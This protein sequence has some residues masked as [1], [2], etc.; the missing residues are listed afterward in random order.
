MEHGNRVRTLVRFDSPRKA[1]IR[2]DAATGAGSSL[3][4]L[5]RIVAEMRHSGADFEDL[6][7]RYPAEW[8]VLSGDADGG[9]RIAAVALSASERRLHRES[10]QLFRVLAV[11][12]RALCEASQDLDT[13]VV[14]HGVGRTDLPTLRG[15]VRAAEYSVATGRGRLFVEPADAVEVE[16]IVVE[17]ADCRAERVRGLRLLG[18]DVR[19]EDLRTVG[20][21]SSPAPDREGSLFH[22]AVDPGRAARERIAAALAYSQLAFYSGNW[23]GMAIVAGAC[24]PVCDQLAEADF[25]WLIQENEE[26]QALPHDQAIEFEPSLLRHP[27]DVRGFLLKVLGIQATGIVADAIESA[28][29]ERGRG[30]ETTMDAPITP[31]SPATAALPVARKQWSDRMAVSMKEA[32]ELLGIC[33]K[34]VERMRDSG[35]IKAFKLGR[36]WRVRVAEL[37]AYVRRQEAR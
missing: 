25:R 32:A 19:Q 2:V 14:V 18:L 36:T 28:K 13:E 9:S 21:V 15:L 4:G 5:R 11:G 12:A 17:E 23:E 26:R 3:A 7:R 20:F 35:V 31:S 27:G 1:I 6:A 24:L 10:E 8:A 37:E 16:P 29:I 30:P 22:I 34:T 33:S